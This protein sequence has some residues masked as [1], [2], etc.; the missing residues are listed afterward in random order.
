MP[1]TT[2]FDILAHPLQYK[3]QKQIMGETK[4]QTNEK[5]FWEWLATQVERNCTAT[6]M[7]DLRTP[8]VE[9]RNK[10][11][12]CGIE[13]EMIGE[14]LFATTKENSKKWAKVWRFM[15]KEAKQYGYKYHKDGMLQAIK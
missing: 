2:Y 9:I 3:S 15:N 8:T 12:E 10:M 4:M 6:N 5:K 11:I 14:K 13:M 1:E 7:V